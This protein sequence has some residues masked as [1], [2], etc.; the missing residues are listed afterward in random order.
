M[1]KTDFTYKI[2]KLKKELKFVHYAQERKNYQLLKKSKFI[3]IKLFEISNNTRGVEEMYEMWF[4]STTRYSTTNEEWFIDA[5]LFQTV[6]GKGF[7]QNCK[8]KIFRIE[9]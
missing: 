3:M 2:K 6:G 1:R 4:N 8:R 7:T 9:I 5:Q